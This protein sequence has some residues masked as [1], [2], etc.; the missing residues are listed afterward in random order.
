MKWTHLSKQ[1]ILF[2]KID[3]EKAYDWIEWRFILSMLKFVGFR[4]MFIN[5]ISMLFK[6]AFA[7]LNLNNFQFDNSSL[8]QSIRQG[9]PVSPSLYILVA[10]AL[11]Y[12]LIVQTS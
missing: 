1:N 9:C 6:Y 2:I 5:S 4:P 7:I 10:K 3:F 8:F 12:L 11:G